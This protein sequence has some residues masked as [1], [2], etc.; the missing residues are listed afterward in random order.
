MPELRTVDGYSQMTSERMSDF[1]FVVLMSVA[2]LV[3]GAVTAGLAHIPGGVPLFV[4]LGSPF[5]AAIA[6][7]LAISGISTNIWKAICLIALTTV[8]FYTARMLTAWTEVH[9]WGTWSMGRSPTVSPYSLFVGGMTGGFIVLG[10]A[11]FL[12]Q[13]KIRLRSLSLKALLWSI[14]GGVL[15]PIGWAAGPFLGL[16]VVPDHPLGPTAAIATFENTPS[17][18]YALYVVWQAGI[19]FAL[20]VVLRPSQAI[21]PSKELESI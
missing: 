21:S 17:H 8:A 18:Q 2:G 11:L 13:P 6:C 16:S 14:F 10:A 5:G 9:L 12:V 20:G 19:A 3:S 15:A 4:L 7:S 1:R